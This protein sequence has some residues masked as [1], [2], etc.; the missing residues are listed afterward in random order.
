MNETSLSVVMPVYNEDKGVAD[1]IA[2]IVR[3]VLDAVPASELVVVD[4]CSTDD[5]SAVLHRIA[6]RDST[7]QGAGERREPRARSHDTTGD[8]RVDR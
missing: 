1:V 8:G 7:G 3:H 6:C 2:D 5:T 4:D